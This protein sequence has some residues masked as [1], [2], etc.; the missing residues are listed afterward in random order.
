[1]RAKALTQ[2]AKTDREKALSVYGFVKAYRFGFPARL[3]FPTARQILDARSL[4]NYWKSTL[5]VALLRLANVP[6]RVRMVKLRGDVLN[7]LYAGLAWV[8]YS[9]AEVWLDGRWVLVDSYTFDAVYMAQARALLAERSLACGY[10]ILRT[11][12]PLWDGKA[13]SLSSLTMDEGDGMPLADFGV[14][15]EP[16]EFISTHREGASSLSHGGIK[17]LPLRLLVPVLNRATRRLRETALQA[18]T[19]TV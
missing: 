9:L 4:N 12:H 16:F 6:A 10:G 1:M 14:F 5:F 19:A 15:N 18:Q 17:D 13:D 2:L 7:G 11:G 3:R 8:N